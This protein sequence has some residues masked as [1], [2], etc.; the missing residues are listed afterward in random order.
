MG[1]FFC[2]LTH[3][4]QPELTLSY[5]S[6]SGWNCCVGIRGGRFFWSQGSGD[7]WRS[8]Y[9]PGE[10]AAPELPCHQRWTRVC[11]IFCM[12]LCP[13][14]LNPWDGRDE[15]V[16]RVFSGC[17]S[18]LNP[19]NGRG[20]SIHRVLP[21]QEYDFCFLAVLLCGSPPGTGVF[22]WILVTLSWI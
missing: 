8:F 18:K 12:A 14:E 1:G 6:V 10:A 13:S 9:F 5:Q 21:K 3:P 7:E 2:P 4:V 17:P 19:W 15:G 22:W 20:Q 11:E 16:P